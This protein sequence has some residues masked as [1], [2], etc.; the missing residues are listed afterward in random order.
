MLDRS[1]SRI[2]LI[3]EISNLVHPT[4][5]IAASAQVSCTA[6]VG[7]F[8]IL[9][10]KVTI[11]RNTELMSHVVIEEGSAIGADVWCDHHT[12]IGKET[13]LGNNV[14]V[15]YGAR[16][17]DHVLIE[18]RAWIAGFVCDHVLVEVGAVVMGKLIHRFVDAV[19]D[20]AEE[21]PIVREGSFVGMDAIVVG[22]IEVGRGAYVAAGAVLTKSAKEGRLYRGV[23]AVDVGVAPSA[24]F[25]KERK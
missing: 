9:G 16:I 21:A 18:E 17:Y 22:G 1:R 24:F 12:Y 2:K 23:P 20:V 4:S 11:D 15:M 6:S 19:E 10:E 25:R 13:T 8:C 14:E 5:V 7:P 3:M